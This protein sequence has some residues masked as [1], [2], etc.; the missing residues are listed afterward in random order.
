MLP[1]DE[2][3]KYVILRLVQE[4][5]LM[6]RFVPSGPVRALRMS[7]RALTGKVALRIGGMAGFESSLERDW[8]IMLDFDRRVRLIQEQPYSL[9]YTT[10]GSRRRYTP[11][12][13]AEFVDGKVCWTT[14]YEV[15]EREDLKA[16]WSEYRP[17]F[18]AAVRD[19]YQKG[20]RFRIV[21]ER[22]IRTPY[23]GN[24]T[25]LRRYRD[26]PEDENQSFALLRTLRTLGPA[27]PQAL[28]AATWNDFERRAVA[29]AAMWR[30]IAY[31]KIAASLNEPLTMKTPIWLP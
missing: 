18:Q 3:E 23:L 5:A 11:D 30:L 9:F 31:G 2:T 19:C 16:N 27:T 10:Q 21:T 17:R 8:I 4:S 26:F 13:L 14:V 28:I 24:V 6:L 29:T 1:D 25:F 22:H 20:W 7:H 12:V 15:K